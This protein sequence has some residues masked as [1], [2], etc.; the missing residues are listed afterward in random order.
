MIRRAVYDV[1]EFQSKY[2]SN[3][4]RH[5]SKSSFTHYL[6]FGILIANTEFVD[7]APYSMNCFK[8]IHGCFFWSL[9]IPREE[10]P[11]ASRTPGAVERSAARVG[12]ICDKSSS[13]A[14]AAQQQHSSSSRAATA[15]AAQRRRRWRRRR[16]LH[17]KRFYQQL[18]S[19]STRRRE[20][21]EERPLKTC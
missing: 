20:E 18:C 14:A 13:T 17:S 6:S 15:A 21:Q 9:R 7:E 3:L 10:S 2:W 5:I 8:V 4:S 12:L 16:R 19:S 1:N 11:L